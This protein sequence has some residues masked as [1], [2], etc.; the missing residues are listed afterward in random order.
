M[1]AC[2]GDGL[3]QPVRRVA[4]TSGRPVAPVIGDEPG[5]HT[6]KGQAGKSAVSSAHS[7]D[8][9]SNREAREDDGEGRDGGL[10]GRIGQDL[11]PVRQRHRCIRR[12][13]K[14]GQPEIAIT[15]L[16]GR[17]PP[18]SRHGHRRRDGEDPLIAERILRGVRET[19]PGPGFRPVHVVV[20]LVDA[21]PH[22][23]IRPEAGDNN[24]QKEHVGRHDGRVAARFPPRGPAA[25]PGAI[26]P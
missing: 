26:Q 9:P 13:T 25:F 6:D 2:D 15:G 1:P 11:G 8:V 19:S 10:V 3:L 22:G 23:S 5:S 18:Q 21:E 4:R 7:V 20:R 24:R 12:K 17:T 14:S 16:D